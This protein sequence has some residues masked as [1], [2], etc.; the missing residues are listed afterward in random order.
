M[1]QQTPKSWPI[2]YLIVN[3][4]EETIR[5]EKLVDEEN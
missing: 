1:Y 4:K 2:Q 3:A 5:E